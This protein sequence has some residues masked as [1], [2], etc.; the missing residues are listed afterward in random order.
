[1]MCNSK[2]N[3]GGVWSRLGPSIRVTH[4]V[5]VDQR[6]CGLQ[7]IHT[8]VPPTSSLDKESALLLSEVEQS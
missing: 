3:E 1:M 5:M 6:I 7:Y 8:E 2:D 4:V